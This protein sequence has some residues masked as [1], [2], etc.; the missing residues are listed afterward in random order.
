MGNAITS[1]VVIIGLS[2]AGKTNLLTFLEEGPNNANPP[3]SIS[4]ND[5]EVK[6][7]NIKFTIYDVAGKVKDLWKHYYG[8]SN[9][10]IWVVDSTAQ[11]KFQESAEALQTAIKDPEVARDCPVLICANKCDLPNAASA[12]EVKDALKLGETL[13]GRSFTV[14]ATD[15]KKGTG[16]NE[17]FKW[18]SDEIKSNRK[19]AKEAAKEKK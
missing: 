6:F 17:G 3:P 10:F 14:I 13:K 4:F 9:A 11:D 19:K 16:I 7:K 15:A 8:G 18:L 1:K 5:R 2:G 12:D